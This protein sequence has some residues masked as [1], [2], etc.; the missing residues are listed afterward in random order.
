M[1][2][3]LW[4]CRESDTTEQL[5]HTQTQGDLKG[6]TCGSLLLA[7]LEQ[8]ESG[9]L[10]ASLPGRDSGMQALLIL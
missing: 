7:H 8:S 5:T 1:G 6:L 3:S 9:H 2:Y 10:V 4:G